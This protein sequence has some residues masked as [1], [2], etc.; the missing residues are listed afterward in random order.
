MADASTLA[1]GDFKAAHATGEDWGRIARA[2]VE[3]LM[4]V[5]ESA[6]IGFVYA[7]DALAGDLGSIIVFLRERTGIADW[8][9]T[10][11]QGILASGVEYHN[12]Q[13][14]SVLVASLPEDGYRVVPTIRDPKSGL[15]PEVVQWAQAQGATFG[16]VHGD[17]RNHLLPE[18]T[19]GICDDAQAFLVGGLSASRRD[20]PQ[21][22]GRLTDGGLSGVLISP[23][24]E[25]VSGLSQGCSPI[26]PMRQI[27]EAEDNVIMAIDD[28]PALEVF[29][30]D[31]GELLARDL[32]RVAGYIFVGFPISG[33]DIGD[34]LVRNLVAIDA[35]NG[36]IGVGEIVEPGRS[37]QFCRRDL[38]AARQDLERMLDDVVRRADGR[39]KA[40]L[41][42]SCL[43]R[44]NNLFG[45]DSEEMKIV[46]DAVGDIPLVGFFANGEI[47]N[48]RLYGF[49]GVLTLFV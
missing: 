25:V 47:C 13:A 32:R 10:V 49:T 34:Y 35:E 33:S 21:I 26:G 2:C 15:D 19:R 6:R 5:P 27:T 12:T 11:G 23:E 24:C 37:V 43:A 3:D 30:E 48:D 40:G 17:P 9:G 31:I 7:T 41:Y 4:P 44:G 38:P 20:Q 36:W 28:R 16:V 14:L 22:A 45:D 42:F 18:I 1:S 29:K 8:F 39:A 46:Q